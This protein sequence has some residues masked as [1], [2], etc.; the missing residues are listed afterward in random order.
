MPEQEI[1][2]E[3]ALTEFI[4]GTVSN[5]DDQV[6]EIL[7]VGSSERETTVGVYKTKGGRQ[8]G[9]EIEDSGKVEVF[10]LDPSFTLEQP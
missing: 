5:P 2:L 6:S 1:D 3:K 4:D 9:F 8:L 7:G 10:T